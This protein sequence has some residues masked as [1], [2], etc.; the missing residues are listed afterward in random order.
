MRKLTV[1][2]LVLLG[3]IALAYVRADDDGEGGSGGGSDG[4]SSSGSGGE[5]APKPQ[6]KRRQPKKA[7]DEEKPSLPNLPMDAISKL[8]VDP[9]SVDAAALKDDDRQFDTLPKTLNGDETVEA[10][11]AALTKATTLLQKMQRDVESEK[12]WTKNVY[13]IIQNYQYKYLKTVRDVKERSKKIAKLQKLVSLIKQSTLKA[14]V[15][16]EL[17]KASNHLSELVSRAGGEKDAVGRYYQ[18]VNQRMNSLKSQLRS[19]PKRSE[20]YSETTAKMKKIMRNKLPPQTADA[21]RQ[22]T[23]DASRKRNRKGKKASKK[24]APKPQPKKEEEDS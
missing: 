15:Q 14:S 18:S 7:A 24:K 4:G 17:T 20:L 3:L 21:I 12:V 6:P 11:T 8:P 23:S 2:A 19:M 22:L 1:V 10:L 5:E 13:D 9:L 16:S